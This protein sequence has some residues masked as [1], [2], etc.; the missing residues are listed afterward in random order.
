M[1]TAAKPTRA[2]LLT[3]ADIEAEFCG[4][5]GLDRKTMSKDFHTCSLLLA[6]ILVSNN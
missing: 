4:K 6:K 1:P 3:Q 2:E 5:H